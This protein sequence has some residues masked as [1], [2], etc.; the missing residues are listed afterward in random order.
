MCHQWHLLL[1]IKSRKEI[2][3]SQT[4]TFR[5]QTHS[6][7]LCLLFTRIHTQLRW[8][9]EWSGVV[10]LKQRLKSSWQRK[11]TRKADHPHLKKHYLEEQSASKLKMHKLSMSA[12]LLLSPKSQ[13]RADRRTVT[14]N[15]A[16][17]RRATAV[18]AICRAHS[19]QNH[20]HPEYSES[21]T[22]KP[23]KRLHVQ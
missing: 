6:F 7:P 8:W 20:L 23:P 11:I 4:G 16:Q 15:Q 3:Q 18:P 21:W 19:P 9:G 17:L 14:M 12:T 5:L 10:G 13:W 22:I 1:S 2:H